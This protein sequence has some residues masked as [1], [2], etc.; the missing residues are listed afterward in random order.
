M[1]GLR[2]VVGDSRAGEDGEAVDEASFG[3][4]GDEDISRKLGGLG[5]RCSSKGLI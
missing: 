3:L 4:S 1:L 5:T 2:V